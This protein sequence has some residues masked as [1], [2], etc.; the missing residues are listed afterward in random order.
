MALLRNIQY[1]AMQKQRFILSTPAIFSLLL[2][3][4]FYEKVRAPNADM[5]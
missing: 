4:G 2:D 3:H 1:I 5:F